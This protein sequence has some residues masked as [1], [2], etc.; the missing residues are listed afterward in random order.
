MRVTIGELIEDTIPFTSEA[1]KVMNVEIIP[2]AIA[3]ETLETLKEEIEY[4]QNT[5][6]RVYAD[7][8]K[9]LAIAELTV[10]E[11]TLNGLLRRF[12]DETDSRPDIRS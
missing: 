7:N 2:R 1:D 11:V 8:E 4:L 3:E 10:I 12:E 6:S 5:R 9:K